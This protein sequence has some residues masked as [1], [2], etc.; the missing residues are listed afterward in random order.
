MK[1][2]IKIKPLMGR[3]LVA[4]AAFVGVSTLSQ[5]THAQTFNVGGQILQRTEYLNGFGNPAVKDTTPAFYTGQRTRLQVEYKDDKFRIYMSPQDIR[6]WGSTPQIKLTDGFLSMHEAFAEVYFTKNLTFKVGRQELDYDDARFLG[7]L[8]WALQAR[9]HDIA[10]MKYADGKNT[11]HVGLA[12]NQQQQNQLAGN[13][14]GLANQYKAA[15]MVWYGR[16]FGKLNT[17]FLMWNNGLQ[18]ASTNTQ[19]VRKE[20]ILYMT[21]IGLPMVEYKINDAFTANAFYYRQIG[22]DGT[23]KDVNAS[24][25]HAELVYTHK[26]DADKGNKLR[27]S[28]GFER[29]SGT[30][31]TQAS[32]TNSSFNPLYGTNHRHNGYMDYFYVGGRQVNSVGLMDVYLKAKYDVNNKLFVSVNGHSFSAAANVLDKSAGNTSQSLDSKLGTEI[33]F[34][35]GY[36]LS[37]AVSIQGGYSQMFATSTLESLRGT[38]NAASNNNWAYVALLIRPNMKNRFTGLKF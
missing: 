20:E 24:D 16:Q 32:T 13:F 29:L 35:V 34:T 33:D 23:N 6:T 25:V 17:S 11:L 30:S 28:G 21:T 19:G 10:L 18:Y 12:Y 15:Q 5:L 22:K 36:I 7:N 8:D 31:Q 37:N 38:M 9:A 2:S 14:Y 27:F 3:K 4:F 26:L 1:L